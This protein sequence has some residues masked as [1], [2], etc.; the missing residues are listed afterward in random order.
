MSTVLAAIDDSAAARPVLATAQA[1]AALWQARVDALHVGDDDGRTA[2]AAAGEAGEALRVE[3]GDVVDRIAQE[4]AN[5]DVDVVVIGA[6]GRPGG[7]RPAGHVAVDLITRCDKPV[8]VVP[9]EAPCGRVLRRFLVALEGTTP[10]SD[11]LRPTIELGRDHGIEVA[12]VH[13]DDEASI[14]LFSDQPQHETDAFAREFLAR[15]GPTVELPSLELRVGEPAE[16]VL[17]T[18]EDTGADIVVVAWSRN[19]A[20]GHARFVR[21]VLEHARIPVMLVPAAGTR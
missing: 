5:A 1:V 2:E 10:T 13:V 3:S 12:V 8:I 15:Y 21:H 14:P 7:S 11:V 6:R 9:P 17:S 20:P 4:A 16:Q 18:C 19:L